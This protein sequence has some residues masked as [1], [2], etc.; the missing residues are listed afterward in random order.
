[1]PSKKNTKSTKS[2]ATTKKMSKAQTGGAALKWFFSDVRPE[3]FMLIAATVLGIVVT[4][5]VF[6]CYA[7]KRGLDSRYGYPSDAPNSEDVSI[8]N[9]EHSTQTFSYNADA[10]CMSGSSF[11]RCLMQKYNASD[12]THA[13]IRSKDQLD[14]LMLVLSEI[15]GQQF[16]SDIDADFFKS[17]SVVAIIDERNFADFKLTN[18]YRDE[19]YGIH[20]QAQSVSGDGSTE[21]KAHLILVSVPNIQ[22]AEVDVKITE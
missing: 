20:L 15:S 8:I 21:S 6:S 16:Q 4:I 13:I 3:K 11:E 14:R 18:A 7:Y 10:Y 17:G 5:L 12:S 22:P 9:V 1:M 2:R 19:K